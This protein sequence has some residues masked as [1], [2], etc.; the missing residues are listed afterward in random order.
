M[1]LKSFIKRTPLYGIIIP[2][3]GPILDRQIR[4]EESEYRKK[5]GE[6][7]LPTGEEEPEVVFRRFRKRLANRGIA[8]PPQPVD[9]GP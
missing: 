5:A 6:M 4:A 3:L 2:F 9:A 8:W 1:G 7:G